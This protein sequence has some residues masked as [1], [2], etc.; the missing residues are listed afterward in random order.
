MPSNQFASVVLGY[1]AELAP[2]LGLSQEE[3]QLAATLKAQ[4]QAGIERYG[5]IQNAQGQAVY[6]YD[7]VDRKSVV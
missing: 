1:V 5:I 4:I 6:A 7:S 3:I 2:F